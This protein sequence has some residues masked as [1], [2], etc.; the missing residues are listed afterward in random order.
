MED[1]RN[2]LTVAQAA[3]ILERSTEQ[4]RR[5][6]REERLPGQRIGGQWFIDRSALHEF[7]D[8]ARARQ[9]FLDRVG[10]ARTLRPLDAVIGIANGT[11]SDVSKGKRTFL[12]NAASRAR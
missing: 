10:A 6:L 9:T 7:A 8:N 1:D 2:L 3:R 5:Y 12:R 4:V 11:G